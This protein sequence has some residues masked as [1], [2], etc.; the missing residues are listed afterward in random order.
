MA[1]LAAAYDRQMKDA[2]GVVEYGMADDAGNNIYKG[3]FV[4][5]DASGYIVPGADT[6][7]C[8]FAG[9]AVETVLQAADPGAE[10]TNKVR[11]YTKGDFLVAYTATLAVTDIRAQMCLDGDNAVDLAGGVSNNVECGHCIAFESTSL[12]WVRIDLVTAA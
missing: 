12:A 11:V 9:V 2:G 4:M 7:S 10:G 8:A 6:S 1:D 5:F 3:A